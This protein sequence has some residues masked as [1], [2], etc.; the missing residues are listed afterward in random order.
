[1]TIASEAAPPM[2]VYQLLSDR[3]APTPL[4]RLMDSICVAVVVAEAVFLGGSYLRGTWLIAPGGGGVATDFVNVWAAGKLALAGHA[5]AA[6]DWPTH[7]FAEVSAVGHPFDGYYGW[8]YPPPFLFVAAALALLPYAPALLLWAAAT[9]SAYLVAIRAIVGDRGGYL[10]AAAF[11]PVIANFFVGQNGF[12][13]AA[14]FGGTL[15]LIERQRPIAAGVLLGLLTYKPHLGVLFPIALIAAGEWRVFVSACIVAVLM[16]AASWLAFGSD[17]W[18]AFVGHIGQSSQAVFAEGKADLT[19]LQTAFGLARDVGG[20]ETAAWIVQAAVALAAAAGVAL[21]WRSRLAYEIKAATLGT[22]AMLVT[23]YLYT[24]DLAVLAVPLAYLFRLGRER[25]FL[26]HELPAI[27]LA[28]LLILIFILPVAKAP[29]GF[30][31][32]L[33]VAAL[34]A[35]RTLVLRDARTQGRPPPPAAN[36]TAAQ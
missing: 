18:L 24:Y 35:Y 31:A 9:F 6:Y 22:A 5:A 29:V 17:S 20:G 3:S 7:K 8:H 2:A 13:S 33:I 30:V 32:V 14:L 1:L 28:C 19:K 16:T 34:I 25:G 27:G 23:P 15:V 11:P 4:P 21:V 26:A 10:L 36:C 12:F